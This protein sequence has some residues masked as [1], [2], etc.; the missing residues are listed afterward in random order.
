MDPFRVAHAAGEDWQSVTEACLAG[1]DPRAPAA[2]LGFIY[3]TEIGGV[4]T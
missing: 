3:A 2:N 4:P 1:L